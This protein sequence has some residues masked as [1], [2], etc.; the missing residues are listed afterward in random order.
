MRKRGSEIGITNKRTVDGAAKAL[1]GNR[2][3]LP[4]GII[5]TLFAFS[6]LSFRFES[7]FLANGYERLLR[8]LDGHPEA[9]AIS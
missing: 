7:D 3:L 1:R 4:A 2:S 5:A 8:Y 6:H 9:A